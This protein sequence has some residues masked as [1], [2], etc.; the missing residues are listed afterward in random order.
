M[1]LRRAAFIYCAL[2]LQGGLSI[3]S[4]AEAAIIVTDVFSYEGE[5]NGSDTVTAKVKIFIASFALA[6]A[7]L[8]G[9][10]LAETEW[11]RILKPKRGTKKKK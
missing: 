3:T 6:E 4:K 9:S 1:F 11:T 2:V 7:F 5:L 8:A 10:R